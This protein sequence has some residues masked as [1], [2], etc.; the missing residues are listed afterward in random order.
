MTIKKFSYPEIRT[1]IAA[2]TCGTAFQRTLWIKI[3]CEMMQESTD[4]LITAI[5]KVRKWVEREPKGCETCD[6]R[7]DCPERQLSPTT[8]IIKYH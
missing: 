8:N 1:K 7:A 2:D 4:Q 6:H 5:K 3:N